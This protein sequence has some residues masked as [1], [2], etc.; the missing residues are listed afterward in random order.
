ML[1]WLALLIAVALVAGAIAPRPARRAE[2]TATT[3][4]T[5]ATAARRSVMLVVHPGQRVSAQAGDIVSLTVP[6]TAPE[7]VM[8]TGLGLS[9][10]ADADTPA[11]LLIVS[12]PAGRYPITLQSTGA[13][14]G[15]LVV[16]AASSPATT[17][18]A[19]ADSPLSPRVERA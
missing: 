7:T 2:S 17:A 4:P 13:V 19:P 16:Q 12:P 18:P 6:V 9:T 14:V 11:S 10:F 8:I 3:Q 5:P 15:T 1:A